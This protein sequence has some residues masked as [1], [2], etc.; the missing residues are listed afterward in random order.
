MLIGLMGFSEAEDDS[1]EDNT[2]RKSRTQGKGTKK[3]EIEKWM[4]KKPQ[5]QYRM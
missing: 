3:D 4:S 5:K 1:D 2:Q